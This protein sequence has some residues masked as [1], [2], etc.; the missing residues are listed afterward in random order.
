MLEHAKVAEKLS[1]D[2][3][4]AYLSLVGQ[5][6]QDGNTYGS[7]MVK[8]IRRFQLGPNI[9]RVELDNKGETCVIAFKGIW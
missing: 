1:F 4:T 7:E 9:V 6:A 8:E 2:E 5:R 3:A